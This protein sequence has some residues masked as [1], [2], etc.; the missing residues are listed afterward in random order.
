MFLFTTYVTTSPTVRLRKTSATNTVALYSNPL[1]SRSRQASDAEISSPEIAARRTRDVSGSIDPSRP[2]KSM[3]MSFASILD[4]P[5]NTVL[6]IS[7][8]IS[9]SPYLP[10]QVYR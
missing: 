3:S 5:V 2:E 8:I 9:Q 4:I 7:F 1:E 10:Q 6:Y